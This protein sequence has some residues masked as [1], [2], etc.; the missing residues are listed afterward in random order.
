[1]TSIAAAVLAFATVGVICAT[2]A[3]SMT[4]SLRETSR[5]LQ[6]PSVGSRALILAAF[7]VVLLY[8]GWLIVALYLAA[9]SCSRFVGRRLPTRASG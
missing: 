8:G 9:C 5:R 6:G 3:W 2:A 4:I 7:F 1:M